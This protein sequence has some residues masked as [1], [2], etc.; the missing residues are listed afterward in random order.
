MEKAKK[1]ELSKMMIQ[2]LKHLHV[3]MQNYINISICVEKSNLVDAILL[4]YDNIP[5]VDVEENNI[6][7]IS[8]A[9]ENDDAKY[10]ECYF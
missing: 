10:Q 3:A 8:D 5:N 7:D 1:R 9:D 2:E 6:N 4:I